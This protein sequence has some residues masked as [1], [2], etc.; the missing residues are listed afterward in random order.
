MYETKLTY[1]YTIQ[2]NFK[3]STEACYSV[4]QIK[5]IFEYCWFTVGTRVRCA[6]Q[7]AINALKQI[8][9]WYNHSF[10]SVVSIIRF[11]TLILHIEAARV[12]KSNQKISSFFLVTLLHISNMV[13]IQLWFHHLAQS[14]LKRT[15]LSTFTQL[16]CLHFAW[17]R[18]WKTK[19]LLH[20][21]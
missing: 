11:S 13:S 6:F 4:H 10:F 20:V 19:L 9:Q 17:V 16:Q 12:L 3:L 7:H 21:C 18:Y 2:R 5:D 1:K 15:I 8:Q 14:Q